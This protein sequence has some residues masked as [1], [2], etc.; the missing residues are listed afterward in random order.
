MIPID[1][2]YFISGV[3]CL[4]EIEIIIYYWIVFLDFGLNRIKLS[5]KFFDVSSIFYHNN[6]FEE[7]AEQF[8]L[9]VPIP[10][11]I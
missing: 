10:Q 2:F 5:L 7:M 3:F 9:Q 6:F 11:N 8:S 4:Y 1:S